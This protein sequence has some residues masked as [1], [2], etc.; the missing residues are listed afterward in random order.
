MLLATALLL[1]V[2]SG[3]K[4]FLVG[5]SQSLQNPGL[6]D[7]RKTVHSGRWIAAIAFRQLLDLLLLAVLALHLCCCCLCWQ[8]LMGKPFG[9]GLGWVLT[10]LAAAAAVA[11]MLLAPYGLAASFQHLCILRDW[12][13]LGN[14]LAPSKHALRIRSHK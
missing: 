10:L 3:D 12:L 8:K 11:G 1:E 6:V 2:A 5:P 13:L 4:G 9:G 14:S 7:S